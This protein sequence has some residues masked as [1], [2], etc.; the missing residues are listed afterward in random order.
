MSFVKFC[1]CDIPSR[2]VFGPTIQRILKIQ[3]APLKK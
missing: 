2:C 3:V 1:H